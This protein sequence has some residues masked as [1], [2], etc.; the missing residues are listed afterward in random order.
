MSA[1]AIAG[2]CYQCA[3]GYRLV[4]NYVIAAQTFGALL[5]IDPFAEG[6]YKSRRAVANAARELAR[7]EWHVSTLDLLGCGDSSGDFADATWDA[8]INDVVMLWQLLAQ[9]QRT[10]PILCALRTGALLAVEGRAP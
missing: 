6:M 2:R 7:N 1:A 5:F 10:T 3:D 9:S 8:W 4:V